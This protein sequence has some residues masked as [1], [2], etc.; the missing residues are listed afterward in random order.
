MVTSFSR[1]T[2]A[3]WLSVVVAA[4]FAACGGNSDVASPGDKFPNKD[5]SVEGSAGDSGII[6][7][8][9]GID[10]G[11]NDAP[12]TFDVQPSALQ[13]ITVP[14]GTNAPTVSYDATLGG[15]PTA[16]A[17]SLDRGDIGDITLG[18]AATGVFTPKGTVG[19]MVKIIAGLNGQTVTRDV[20][21]N[22]TAEQNGADPN[23]PAQAA[24]IANTVAELTEGGGIG[25]VGGDGLGGA[26]TDAG[27]L[28]ALGTP[29]SNGSAEN[30]RLIYPYD[31]TVFPRGILAPILSWD[32]SV[33]DADAIQIE[34]ATQSGSFSYK[35]TFAKPAI[36]SQ[37]G[38]K[39]IRHPIP[40]NIWAAATNT[41][42]G[43]SD[44]LTLKL[45]LAKDGVGYGPITETWT[46]APARLSG[47]IYYNSY[48]T[49]LAKNYGGAVGGDHMFGGA[50]LSIAVG[51]TGP[52]LVAGGNGG[53]S[54]C[55]VCHSVAADGS[56]LV[57]QRGDNYS[58]SAA[59]DLTPT[60]VTETQMGVGAEF[61]GIYPDGSLAL[62]PS[63]QVLSLP[64]AG[65]PVASTGLTS[66][67]TNVGT[68]MFS[69]DGK[70][71][72]FNPMAGPGVTN[73]T[74][75]LVVMD[76]DL[77]TMTFSNPIE[78]ADETGQPAESRPGWP[79]FFPDSKGIAFHLQSVAGSDGNGIG[80]M[81]TRKG[82]KAQIHFTNTDGASSSTPLYRLNGF[83]S[84]GAPDL[85]KL[86][87]AV[88]LACTGDGV[89]VGGID[90]DHGD[91]VNLNYEPTVNPIAS[92]GYVWVVFTSRR[93]YGNVATIPP[94]CSDPRGVDLVQHITTKKLWVAAVDVNMAPG[95]DASHP[96]F[97]LP[98]QELLAGNSRAFWV[99]DPCRADGESCESGDQCCN[100]YC[101]PDSTT[102]ELVCSNDTPNNNCSNP[103]EKCTT[104]AD[105]C[106]KSNLCLNGF[107]SQQVP[108]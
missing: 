85:P 3:L 93:M 82:A 26:V 9:G 48:G 80:A 105:C 70:R 10:V 41:A 89:Q 54:Q 14:M 84:T 43:K 52:K 36:L 19:G 53:T 101:Q 88:S 4:G 91:D 27:A 20:Q 51:D 16:V 13:T 104:A 50:V 61:P 63:G 87:T 67:A 38:G 59:Y 49:N 79:A 30:L 57:V 40:G 15:K 45:T 18:T 23:D 72:V 106:D 24:Q 7:E 102:G 94:F 96:A 28:A 8:G 47:I 22:L 1:A 46:I 74:Q 75:K 103:K 90:A 108:Q 71:V 2:V 100:G 44:Q 39:F 12:Q 6:N 99:Q 92:G 65:A 31:E 77:A 55:R 68:P 58:A 107:C 95:T 83:D 78:V 37:T 69:P 34:L 42:G 76:F 64:T 62:S 33:G 56:R 5:A 11:V 17:W 97:Y 29:T 35:G 66:V 60:G 32:W 86:T 73:P 21:V 25:G 98:G 81:H